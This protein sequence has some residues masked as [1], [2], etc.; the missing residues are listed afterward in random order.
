MRARDAPPLE[1]DRPVARTRAPTRDAGRSRP[2]RSPSGRSPRGLRGGRAS[3][4]GTA[5]APGS[6]NAT[7][8]GAVPRPCRSHVA[9]GVAL[10]SRRPSP[11]PSRR[12]LEREQAVEGE[13]GAGQRRPVVSPRGRERPRSGRG[14]PRCPRAGARTRRRA[15]R[16]RAAASA[17]EPGGQLAAGA[18]E[19]RELGALL[20][21]SRG[22]ARRSARSAT[23]RWHARWSVRP[24]RRRLRRVPPVEDERLAE[25]VAVRDARGAAPRGRSPRSRRTTCRTGARARRAPRGRPAPSG[26]RTATRRAPPS[27]RRARR[28]ASDGRDPRDR[29]PR[30]RSSPVPTT[31]AAGARAHACREP[32][33]PR[34]TRDVVRVEA[35]DVA[36]R[37]TRR[38]R[39]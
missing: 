14:G 4:S 7:R 25:V 38:S 15:R 22:R 21:P 6:T 27:A 5:S 26:G 39:R 30:S 33:E 11:A 23:R 3:G 37:A 29:R 13:R 1:D 8:T 28:T 20:E 12:R 2:R 32:L 36:R 24:A 34:R 18:D 9:A 31:A 17:A 10:G 16:A 35:R 19:P